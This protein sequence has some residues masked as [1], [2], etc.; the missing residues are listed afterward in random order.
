MRPRTAVSKTSGAVGTQAA[1]GP[2]G[3]EIQEKVA[4]YLGICPVDVS[5][6]VIE[7]DRHAEMVCWMALVTSTLDKIFTEF[8]P[9][10]GRRSPRKRKASA[11]SR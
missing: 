2:K 6:Q 1:Y 10:R 3:I 11:R 7:R 5:N 9:F 8:E 4:E